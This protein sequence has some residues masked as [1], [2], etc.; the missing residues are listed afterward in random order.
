MLAAPTVG[1]VRAARADWNIGTDRGISFVSPEGGDGIATAGWGG[2]QS[3]LRW[4]FPPGVR[5]G[6]TLG[7]PTSEIGIASTVRVLSFDGET[8]RSLQAMASWQHN[9]AIEQRSRF[10]VNAG[11]GFTLPGDEDDSFSAAGP[12]QR[13]RSGSAWRNAGWSF[14]PGRGA[15]PHASG[16]YGDGPRGGRYSRTM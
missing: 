15:R 1:A 10:F 7:S 3:I 14:R 6:F 8:L 2:G 9:F 11:L 5:V 16:T 12:R 13:S 4:I